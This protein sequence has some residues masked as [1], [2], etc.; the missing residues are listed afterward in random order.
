[1]GLATIGGVIGA[2][3]ELL[4]THGAKWQEGWAIGTTIGG[5]LEGNKTQ[6]V[7]KLSDLH[8]SGSSY[9]TV[10]PMVWGKSR[11]G[12]SIIWVAN[13]V[14][15]KTLVPSYAGY[16]VTCQA[17][18]V[19][20][21]HITVSVNSNS[22]VIPAGTYQT[23]GGVTV[24]VTSNASISGGN[25]T[26][27]CSA[28]PAN[29][30]NGAIIAIT[31]GTHLVEHKKTSSSGGGGSGG[32]ASYDTYWYTASF[33]V[34]VCNAGMR[35]N[36][37]TIVN[38]SPV[39]KRIW[40]NDK[41]VYDVDNPTSNKLT[42]RFYT[43][44][45][46]Q[47]ADTLISTAEGAANAPA[48]RGICYFVVQ[49]MD[50]T[51]YGQTIPQFQVEV[52]TSAVNVG[53]II[54]D[55][56]GMAGLQNLSTTT[57]LLASSGATSISVTP[58]TAPL[59]AGA[60]L[61]F[62]AVTATLTAA[63]P[64][65]ATTLSVS[66][67]SGSIALNTSATLKSVLDTSAAT[68]SV[69]GFQ[70]TSLQSAQSAL[71]SFI[72]LYQT[73]LVEAGGKVIAVPRGGSTSFNIG[74][75]DMGAVA[76]GNEISTTLTRTRGVRGELPGQVNVTY[77]DVNRQYQQSTQSDIKQT[78]DFTNI[79]ALGVPLSLSAT[80]ARQMASRTLETAFNELDPFNFTTT[81]KYL[82][83]I[84]TDVGTLTDNE[85]LQ[86]R[87]RIIDMEIGEPGELKFTAV[88]DSTS[89]AYQT[90]V[91]DT[92]SGGSGG[93]SNTP[94]PSTF[95]AWSGIELQDTDRS[96]P[97]FYVGATGPS[98]W[99]GGVVYYS[100]DGGS[101]WNQ[102]PTLNDRTPFGVTTSILANGT[103][104]DYWDTTNSVG[105]NINDD[106]ILSLGTVTQDAVMNGNNIAMIG[107]E[108]CGFANVSPTGALTYTLSTLRRGMRSSAYTSHSSGEK[109]VVTTTALARVS[110][111]SSYVGTSVLVK[112]VSPYQT[113]SDVTAQSVTIV[114]RTLTASEQSL[115]THAALIASGSQ[116]GHVKVGTGLSI[117]GSGVLSVTAAP[118]PFT[119]TAG[120]TV[121]TDASKGNLYR[122]TA[123]QNFTLSNPTNMTDG[124]LVTWE[125]IQ[126]ATGSRVITLGTA[127]ALGTDIAS[128][129]LTTTASKRDFLTARYNSGTSK[130]YVVDLKRG[131]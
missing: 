104:N 80:E 56:C 122:L 127:F 51:D 22:G 12:G 25:A 78:A 83:I 8:V 95:I 86:W 17:A 61:T 102:G 126:D 27:S 32:G 58:L 49:D 1:M 91:G 13:Y 9:G 88:V 110:L 36:D 4:I 48:Y 123:N 11:V 112:V 96:S 128:V 121:A 2:G 89:V 40:A 52:W 53:N 129:V 42:I 99:R 19:G 87:V 67:L 119:L 120:A 92:G 82:S 107:S 3:A 109:F 76:Q 93:G 117:D 33:A 77:F 106:G 72:G 118:G 28:L 79:N 31:G 125:I 14:N 39:I 75:A 34:A 100:T 131:Y 50:L 111:A 115:T 18:T 5:I 101:T 59:L 103:G 35:M 116:L 6:S 97:G 57:T 108:L 55:L 15:N 37:G 69:T 16:Q 98:T 54:S 47:V 74:T 29:I 44:T 85:G 114:A 23:D 20:A 66:A 65:G 7:G 62:G 30:P 45:E 70:T 60:T 94:I 81:W 24:T 113:L 105:V 71:E 90:V 68:A 41:V 63:A 26:L 130:W 21:T 10:Y 46:I 64:M 43:G 73:D 84:P 124:Q 38:H